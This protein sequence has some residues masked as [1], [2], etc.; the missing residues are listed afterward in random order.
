[1]SINVET[2]IMEDR[3]KGIVWMMCAPGGDVKRYDCPLVKYMDMTFGGGMFCEMC[4]H[5]TG[6]IVKQGL[7]MAV[8]CAYEQKRKGALAVKDRIPA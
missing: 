8:R 6:R 3:E 4:K 5:Y 2:A 1:M 7:L